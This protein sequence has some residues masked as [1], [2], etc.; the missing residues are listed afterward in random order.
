MLKEVAM[1][2]R[3]KRRNRA[4]RIAKKL[5]RMAKRSYAQPIGYRM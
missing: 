2:R 4:K 1:A 5:R 3:G